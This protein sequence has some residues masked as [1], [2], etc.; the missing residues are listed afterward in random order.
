[1]TSLMVFNRFIERKK[2]DGGA[3]IVVDTSKVLSRECFEM[4]VR[5]RR[6]TPRCPEE[7]FR[8]TLISY[9]TVADGASKPFEPEVEKDLLQHLRKRE[10]WACFRGRKSSSGKPILI[11][12]NGVRCFGFHEC[13]GTATEPFV[14]SRRREAD[15][16]QGENDGN[17]S[18]DDHDSSALADDNDSS[19]AVDASNDRPNI[20]DH[21]DNF[22]QRESESESESEDDGDNIAQ[23]N[24]SSEADN[25][26]NDVEN[27]IENNVDDEDEDGN[28]DQDQEQDQDDNN[29]S[30]HGA[31]T[32]TRT[33]T[34]RHSGRPNPTSATTHSRTERSTRSD[35]SKPPRR[36]GNGQARSEEGSHKPR[37]VSDASFDS[38]ATAAEPRRKR[39]RNV[40]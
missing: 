10:V 29:N 37:S 21:H 35:A 1:M 36:N 14:Q 2:V 5:S 16:E 20:G 31:S 23:I 18:A 3:R 25:D 30:N 6:V 33:R 11:G 13:R 15:K 40:G 17:D 38:A 22:D 27:N 8:K 4:W 28:Q 19:E 7:A 24:L 39:Q 26:G 32:R 12:S 34:G 9:I